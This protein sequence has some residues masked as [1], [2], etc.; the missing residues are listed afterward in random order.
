[1]ARRTFAEVAEITDA[2]A[3]VVAGAMNNETAVVQYQLAGSDLYSDTLGGMNRIIEQAAMEHVMEEVNQAGGIEQFS[4]INIQAMMAVEAF[5]QVSGLDLT[6]VLLRAHYLRI[7]QERNLLVNHP[8]QY[9]NLNMM[10]AQNGC[11]VTDMLATLDMVNVLFPYVSEELGIPVHELWGALGKSKIKEMLPVLKSLITGEDSDTATTRAA[12]T[13]LIDE[14]FVGF[15]A[16]PE[17]VDAV[18]VLDNE[19]ADE[20]D[21]TAVRERLAGIA[22]RNIVEHLIELGGNLPV[23]EVRRHLRPE[24]TNPLPFMII[25]D[26]RGGFLL[27]GQFDQDQMNML[28]NKMGERAEFQEYQLPEDARARQAEAFR[29]P[30]L[31]Q[32]YNDVFGGR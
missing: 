2:G 22:R 30:I 24:R 7:I 31:R 19:E 27:T 11:S 15:R 5:R 23:Q 26:G 18:A 4:E 14:Q 16:D 21:R 1:M 12:V 28:R 8:S 32:L 25:P 29:Y 10:A 17:L 6:A 20:A 9:T 3:L 13:R